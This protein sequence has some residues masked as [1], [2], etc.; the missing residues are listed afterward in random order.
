MTVLGEPFVV[1]EAAQ[2][3]EGD[4]ALARLLV[5]GA[6]AAGAD[7]VKFQIVFAGDLAAPDYVHFDL[8]T[9][10][11]MTEADWRRV[12]DDARDKGLEFFAD[13]FGSQSLA[14]AKSLGVDGIKIHSTCFF[15]DALIAEV[16]AMP[17]RL[18]LSIGGIE[19][20]ELREAVA[21]H[22]LVDRPHETVIMYGFQAEPTPLAS[23]HLRRIPAIAKATG[24]EVGFMDH[25][26]G[27]GDYAISLSAVALGL[28][29]R[30][31]EKHISL[32]HALALE[33]HISALTPT[34]F[35]DYVTAMADLTQ[36][37]GDDI[38]ALSEDERAYRGR[39]LKRVV[40]V[41][42]IAAGDVLR[43]EDVVLLRPAAEEGLFR[44]GDA[45]GRSAKRSIAA[46]A[47]VRSGDLS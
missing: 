30:V 12:R 35:A 18:L 17:V 14:L 10:L 16:A 32:D 6:A 39:A 3:Y 38:P 27:Q 2:G 40:A 13:I 47:P 34:G 19:M 8:F 29:A 44:P 7:A 22:R 33:D 23:N 4:P 15:D 21:R 36:A 5:R 43:E 26:E 42:D 11:E 9:Q 45:I 28:G 37:L 25:S 31:F 24:L 41:R 1:A 20:E 46:G